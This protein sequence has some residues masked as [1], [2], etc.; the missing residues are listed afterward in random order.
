MKI[1]IIG[2]RGIPNNY[3]GFEQFAEFL[4]RSLIARG[5]DVWVCSPHYHYF[6]ANRYIGVNIKHVFNPEKYI[7]TTGNFIYDFLCMKYA[8]G[9]SA[10]V[11]LML[12]YTTS[13][14]WF[15]FFK[16]RKTVM[17]TNMDG[18]E[19]QRSKWSPVIKK[20]AKWF[21][22]LAVKN[23]KYLISDHPVIQEY[24][25]NEY[26]RS[27]FHIPYGANVFMHPDETIL[28]KFSLEK[29]KYSMLIARLEEGHHIDEIIDGYLAAGRKEPFLVIGNYPTKYGKKLSD[30]YKPYAQV[31]FIGFVYKMSV[32]NNLRYYSEYYFHGHSIGGTNPSLLEAMAS[33]ALIIAHANPFNK[34]ILGDDGFYFNDTDEIKQI[35]GNKLPDEETRKMIVNNNYDKIRNNYRWDHVVNAYEKMFM[36]INNE[37]S[38]VT[39][40]GKILIGSPE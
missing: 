37:K 38:T 17:V 18:M 11:I 4:S 3:G 22:K 40:S 23:C 28:E 36:E 13:S 21:E 20:L 12:G 24:Y 2:S 33:G 6:K 5:H 10:D 26:D 14:V 39:K 1:V 27:S 30:K 35:L 25:Q 32:L 9:A 31:R 29:R 15:Y 34:Y 7:G 8:F 16:N 19:W